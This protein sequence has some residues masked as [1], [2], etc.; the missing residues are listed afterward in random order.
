MTRGERESDAGSEASVKRYL[1]NCGL[2]RRK[3]EDI[4]EKDRRRKFQPPI[5]GE[6]IMETYGLPPCRQIGDIKAAIK[7]AILDGRIPNEYDAAY[8]LMEQLAADCGLTK[9]AGTAPAKA[10]ASEE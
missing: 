9:V 5:S 3:L 6:L 10:E 1:K 2:G 8:A 7:D 4:E